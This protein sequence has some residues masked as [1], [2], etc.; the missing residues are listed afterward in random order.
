MCRYNFLETK[1]EITLQH[2][3]SMLL[4]YSELKGIKHYAD[5]FALFT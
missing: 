4:L 2:S 1:Q 3:N 5:V